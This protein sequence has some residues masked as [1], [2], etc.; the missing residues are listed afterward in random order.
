MYLSGLSEQSRIACRW[1]TAGGSNPWG[2]VAYIGDDSM[3]HA[4]EIRLIPGKFKAV[5]QDMAGRLHKFY[6]ESLPHEERCGAFDGDYISVVLG[7]LLDHQNQ[8]SLADMVLRSMKEPECA[9]PLSRSLSNV[10][11]FSSM[12]GVV[13]VVAAMYCA[14][15]SSGDVSLQMG[16]FFNDQDRK[17][18][19][20]WK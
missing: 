15:C 18:A 1:K 4:K 3:V 10:G 19:I 7:C 11:L 6:C 12:T 2:G 5:C 16:L 20:R 14:A 17:C 9:K 13:A 8:L